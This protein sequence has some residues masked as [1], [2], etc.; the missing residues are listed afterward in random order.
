M[1]QCRQIRLMMHDFHGPGVADSG[2][3]E[4]QPAKSRK[5]KTISLPLHLTHSAG[6]LSYNWVF[7]NGELTDFTGFV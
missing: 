6:W 1:L 2:G 3:Q 7:L 4:G 5:G